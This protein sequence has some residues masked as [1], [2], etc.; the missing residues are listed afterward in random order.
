MCILGDVVCVL[1]DIDIVPFVCRSP[2]AAAEAEFGGTSGGADPE[3]V[4]RLLTENQ[5]LK[6][7]LQRVQLELRTLQERKNVPGTAGGIASARNKR[8]NKTEFG[9]TR[10][11]KAKPSRRGSR[12]QRRRLA[13]MRR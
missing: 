11:H 6:M 10:V 8:V 4:Q 2:Q 9:Q 7:E 12:R 5:Q 3:Q 1:C 13:D